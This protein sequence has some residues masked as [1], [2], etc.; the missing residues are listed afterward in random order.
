MTRGEWHLSTIVSTGGAVLIDDLSYR[1]SFPD[2]EVFEVQVQRRFLLGYKCIRRTKPMSIDQVR[3][4]DRE[5]PPFTLRPNFVL[6]RSLS[7]PLDPRTQIARYRC[8]MGNTLWKCSRTRS[9]LAK[10]RSRLGAT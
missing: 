8:T 7:D 2:D 5:H 1:P 9:R 4:G 10:S 3:T 6:Y